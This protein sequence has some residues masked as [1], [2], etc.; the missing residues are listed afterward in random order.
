MTPTAERLQNYYPFDQDIIDTIR[1]VAE[2]QQ[3]HPDYKDYLTAMGVP[4]TQRV[5]VDGLK[6]I[7][8]LDI[9]PR[10]DYDDTQARVL[11]LPMGNDVDPNQVYQAATVFAAEPGKRLIAVGNPSAPGR[12]DGRLSI[13]DALRVANGD[14]RPTVDPLLHYL[15]HENITHTEHIG[16]SYGADKVLTAV[17][18]SAKYDQQPGNNVALEPASVKDRGGK[19]R[20]MLSIAG[21]FS[22]TA[23]HL[24]TYVNATNVA[25]FTAARKESVGV[26]DYSL[27]LAR[28]SNI[29]IASALATDKFES[30]AIAALEAQPQARLATIWGT[31]SELAIN[32]LMEQLTTRLEDRFPG[33]TQSLQL[34]GQTHSLANDIHLQAALVLQGVRRKV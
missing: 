9:K 18:H 32:G 10:G 17:A 24:D 6:P 1:E 25:A 13:G 34:P 12:K 30:R 11:H 33:R 31:E 7:R 2:V 5:M 28:L 26:V 8:V 21:D 20:A 23:K 29:A 3:S 22:A 14:L 27:G 16:Y 4:D 15:R 19:L